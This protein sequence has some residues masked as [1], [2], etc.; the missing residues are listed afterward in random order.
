[1]VVAHSIHVVIARDVEG[2]AILV[3][4]WVTA[5]IFCGEPATSIAVEVQPNVYRV[6]RIEL[7]KAPE[8]PTAQNMAD[9]A[10][11]RLEEGKIVGYAEVVGMALIFRTPC[12][13]QMWQGIRDVIV[14]LGTGA[15][16]C[17]SRK[18]HGGH[19]Q[20]FRFG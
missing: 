17:A 16:A 20:Q 11:F 7:H 3:E 5:R 9:E 1:M 6:A 14:R 2:D 15:D 4:D 13:G 10:L 18:E 12:V 8:R 19:V